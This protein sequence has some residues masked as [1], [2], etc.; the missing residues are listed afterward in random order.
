MAFTL[1]QLRYCNYF[2]PNNS[3]AILR[4]WRGCVNHLSLLVEPVTL[5]GSE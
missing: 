4:G 2:A 1:A 3:P 5:G